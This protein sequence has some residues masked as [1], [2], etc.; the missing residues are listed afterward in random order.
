MV[1]N[2]ATTTTNQQQFWNL[3]QI[4][5]LD[6]SILTEAHS[7]L[8]ASLMREKHERMSQDYE[9]LQGSQ[10]S[11]KKQ[12]LCLIGLTVIGDLADEN[13]GRDWQLRSRDYRTVEKFDKGY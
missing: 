2:E 8:N 12:K 5:S 11:V 7:S 4:V 9:K 10:V 13:Q 3:K 6:S 1:S